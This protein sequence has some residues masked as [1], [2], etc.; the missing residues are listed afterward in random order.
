MNESLKKAIESLVSVQGSR[1]VSLTYKSKGTKELARHTLLLGV[2]LDK[3]Y[4]RDL[5]LYRRKLSKL[6]GIEQ[7]ACQELVDSLKE[8]L[9]V[10]IGNNSA[11]TNKDTYQHVTSGIKIHL[12]SDDIHLN[13]FTVSKVKICQSC[14][15]E[16]SK[17]ET[18][19]KCQASLGEYKEVK[20][21]DKTLAKNRLRKMGKLG[22]IRQFILKES[23]LQSVAC[24]GKTLVIN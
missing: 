20:S 6:Q 8:S 14:A 21:S 22:K 2:K 13:G 11:N 23:E 19:D 3:V 17:G 24:N 7:V 5:S 1:F 12:T 15:N 10:G 4:K 16:G 9:T 18:C